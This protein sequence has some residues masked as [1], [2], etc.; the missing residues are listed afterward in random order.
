MNTTETKA[1]VPPPPCSSYLQQPHGAA[2]AKEVQEP[3]EQLSV[4]REWHAD[5]LVSVLDSA[6]EF[7]IPGESCKIIMVLTEAVNERGPLYCEFGD[8]KVCEPKASCLVHC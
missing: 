7:G 5:E 3:M 6:P 4:T 2:A 8:H 1:L